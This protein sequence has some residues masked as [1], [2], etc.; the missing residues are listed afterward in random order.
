MWCDD[1]MR[2]VCVTQPLLPLV[3]EA[4]LPYCQLQLTADGD[5]AVARVAEYTTQHH[6]MYIA[7]FAV[8]D[9]AE[10]AGEPPNEL[11]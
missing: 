9:E 4:L 7:T 1:G 5:S 11:W 6:S 2:C 10:H 3:A 8:K